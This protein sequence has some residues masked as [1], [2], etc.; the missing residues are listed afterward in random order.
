MKKIINLSEFKKNKRKIKT[1]AII[2]TSM[3]TLVFYFFQ[4][5]SFSYLKENQKKLTDSL[6]FYQAKLVQLEDEYYMRNIMIIDSIE[7][8]GSKY[9]FDQRTSIDLMRTVAMFKNY[10][11]WLVAININYYSY[12]GLDSILQ[13][14]GVHSDWLYLAAAE[15]FLQQFVRSYR[16]ATGLWQ[17]LSTRAR[18]NGL[19]VSYGWD[20]RRDAALST[21]AAASAFS[22]L[23]KKYD[24]NMM[25]VSADWNW[26]PGS[27]NKMLRK[28]GSDYFFN[29]PAMPRETYQYVLNILSLA[30][31]F[32]ND[33]DFL[34]N[35]DHG[36]RYN[37]PPA[38]VLE[39][40]LRKQVNVQ[41]LLDYYHNS[42]SLFYALN[43]PINIYS[44]PAYR[45]FE[46]YVPKESADSLANFLKENNFAKKITF[47]KS[48]G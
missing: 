30:Y 47:K 23:L 2:L 43:A 40:L 22:Y 1:A 37:L 6:E 20:E 8:A 4:W 36:V 5:Q 21:R 18:E 3:V 12:Q 10:R 11:H 31:L 46:L 33:A 17:F 25:L 34:K 28:S 7:F 27:L 15:S 16:G 29:L 9:F 32:K 44:L 35:F 14:Y 19:K 38:D 42:F 45:Q 24:G 48:S 41:D 13:E 26:G 39:V